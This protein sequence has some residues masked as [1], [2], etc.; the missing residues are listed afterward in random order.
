MSTD[1]KALG[2]RKFY[3][4]ATPQASP[5]AN[6]AAYAAL[7]WVEVTGVGALG[8]TGLKTNILT[9]DMWG[10]DVVSKDK[11][12]SNAGDP[13]L[14]VARNPTDAG[15]II[16]NTAAGTRYKYAFKVEADDKPA[17]GYTNT[18]WYH[19]GLVSG[20]THPNGRTEDFDLDVFT[21]GLVQREI[22]V[23][24]AAI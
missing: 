21:L 11:G 13:T 1:A 16:L 18:V 23:D 10:T 15:Q 24:P 2:A 17:D 4:C 14:E 20:P 5:L 6:A 7:T 12:T 22:K 9:Y 3:V 19:R 8:E